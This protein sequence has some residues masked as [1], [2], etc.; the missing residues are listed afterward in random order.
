MITLCQANPRGFVPHKPHPA[1]SL[2]LLLS[3]WEISLAPSLRWAPASGHRS[4]LVVQGSCNSDPKFV[5]SLL[6]AT[7]TAPQHFFQ[8]SSALLVPATWLPASRLKFPASG[9]GRSGSTLP[10]AG[11]AEPHPDV[12]RPGAWCML[13]Q[14][15]SSLGRGG[16]LARF[17][18][19]ASR[20]SQEVSSAEAKG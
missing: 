5:V 19:S 16:S 6:E 7:R 8:H 13:G 20:L 11:P 18:P 14:G 9:N 12:H 10:L 2:D 17:S 4:D 3:S 15:Y 1:G